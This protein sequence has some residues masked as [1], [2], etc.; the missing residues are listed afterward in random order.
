MISGLAVL[1]VASDP[2]ELAGRGGGSALVPLYWIVSIACLSAGKFQVVGIPGLIWSTAEAC[3]RPDAS[4][5]RVWAR[6]TAVSDL[7]SP[8]DNG[9]PVRV[10]PVFSSS[11]SAA[12]SLAAPSVRPL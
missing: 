8:A 12:R 2:F 9:L 1:L 7:V 4:V 10:S 5:S 11:H 6:L 3:F